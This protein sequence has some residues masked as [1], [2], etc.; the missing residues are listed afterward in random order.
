MEEE[1]QKI[2]AEN[3]LKSFEELVEKYERFVYGIAYRFL[4]NSQ[5][6]EDI[7]QEV[8]LIAFRKMKS[9]RNSD[10]LTNWIY[11]ITLN[12]L[13]KNLRERY[14]KK[15]ILNRL[16]NVK[17][18]LPSIIEE[19]NKEEIKEKIRVALERLSP[20]QKK[21]I[22]LKFFEGL[23]IKEISEITNCKEGTVKVHIFRGVN[24]LKKILKNE[25]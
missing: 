18:I 17:F 23:K 8:F 2:L 5:D 7:T 6:A 16:G 13:R 19:F 21:V 3:G 1:I 20:M 25:M 10:S 15:H 4:N 14:R 9:L 12:L 22:E 11:K 24:S